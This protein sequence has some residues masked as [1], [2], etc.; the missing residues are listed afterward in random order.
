MVVRG[1]ARVG[2]DLRGT[3]GSVTG[4]CHRRI[5]RIGAG[6]RSCLDR[7]RWWR[8]RIV[9]RSCFWRRALLD[10]S[11]TSAHADP[12]GDPVVGIL[13]RHAE[14][15]AD[16]VREPAAPA[17]LVVEP[18]PRPVA[19]DDDRQA[20]LAA[21]SPFLAVAESRPAQ[22]LDRKLRHPCAQFAI[23]GPP[24]PPAHR[25]P[26]KACRRAL[27]GRGAATSICR[28]WQRQM[29]KGASEPV[30]ERCC[31]RTC[32]SARLPCDVGTAPP[33]QPAPHRKG[34]TPSR[35][36]MKS[37]QIKGG[38]HWAKPPFARALRA[39]DAN[40]GGPHRGANQV[41]G[42]PLAARCLHRSRWKRG[43]RGSGAQ[44]SRC[45]S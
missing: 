27:T 36:T 28:R 29:D 6:L 20:A 41:N 45:P 35:K 34:V 39:C 5:G 8:D 43:T 32:R 14:V 33:V 12:V 31:P 19:R 16:E 37:R 25:R 13:A 22:Q 30:R 42:C 9:R 3:R 21:P 15:A 1:R 4:S 18:H 10:R 24:V 11:R 26:R 38:P 17:F 23:E 7:C 40:V 44:R 2:P